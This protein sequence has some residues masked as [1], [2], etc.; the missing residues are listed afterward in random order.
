VVIHDFN[1]IGVPLAPRKTN[2]PLVVDASAVLTLS[3]TFEALQAISW[4]RR[5]RSEIRRGVEHSEFTKGL[6]LDGLEPANSFSMEEALGISASEGP[7]HI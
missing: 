2:P 3:I 1:F 7:D 6:A 5:E 4:Q